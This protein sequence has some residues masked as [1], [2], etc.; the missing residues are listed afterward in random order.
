MLYINGIHQ[1]RR[2]PLS[3]PKRIAKSFIP[4]YLE[5]L[6]LG[7]KKARQ[8]INVT[9]AGPPEIQNFYIFH[10]TVCLTLWFI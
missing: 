9:H 8:L 2:T 5:C 10:V 6:I 3:E 7:L 1:I 4:I